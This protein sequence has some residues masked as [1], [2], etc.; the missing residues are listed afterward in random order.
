MV[1]GPCDP[2]QASLS[3]HHVP[4]A[5]RLSVPVASPVDQIGLAQLGP[6]EESLELPPVDESPESPEL[7]DTEPSLFEPDDELLV[8]PVPPLEPEPLPEEE[9]VEPRPP[10]DEL[11][12]DP[13]PPLEPEPLPPLEPETLPPLEPEL[14]PL[15]S[16]TSPSLEFELPLR[17]L[18]AKSTARGRTGITRLSRLGSM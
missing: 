17:Q 2:D 14:P 12:V 13:V 18:T 1:C 11:P 7:P 8:G 9:L 16:T 10:D 5:S 3:I 4:E 15:P 6:D